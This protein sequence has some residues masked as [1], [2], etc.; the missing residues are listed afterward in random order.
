MVLEPEE[1]LPAEDLV[2]ELEHIAKWPREHWKLAFQGQIRAVSEHDAALLA[3]ACR[4]EP[5]PGRTMAAS[6]GSPGQA[7]AARAGGAA[8]RLRRA[9]RALA[10]S[11]AN[12]RVA[13]IALA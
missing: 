10:G 3:G 1:W 13:A 7:A 6:P 2:G 9:W 4:P 8:Q 11:A 5:A 12:R